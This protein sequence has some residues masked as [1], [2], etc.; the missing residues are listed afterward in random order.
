V[1]ETRLTK[2]RLCSGHDALKRVASESVHLSWHPRV[3]NY[4]KNSGRGRFFVS[5]LA[6][7]S[8]GRFFREFQCREC[9]G[10]QAYHSRPHGFFEKRVL[11]LLML[12]PV[13][14]EHCFHRGYVFRTVP[15]L[16]RVGLPAKLPHSGPSA[17][18]SPGHRV[19]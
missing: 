1:G 18:S 16:E 19:A 9:G 8:W 4:N 13:R 10:Q 11:P 14:C 5:P 17:D 7:P 12:Q 3:Y 6:L 15:A 2:G